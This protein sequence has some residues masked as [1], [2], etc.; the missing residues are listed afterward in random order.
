MP[1]ALLRTLPDLFAP[2]RTDAPIEEGTAYLIRAQ[3][4]RDLWLQW[5]VSRG[6][7]FAPSQ[8]E[9]KPSTM[10]DRLPSLM[11]L[12]VT[13]GHDLRVRLCGPD[14]ARLFAANPTGRTICAG[15]TDTRI[16]RVGDAARAVL[17]SRLPCLTR[18]FAGPDE[19]SV[20][21]LWLPLSSDGARICA[22]LGGLWPDAR[23]D[24]A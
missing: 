24:Q 9:M 12:S 17:Q 14:A 20:E 5:A 6:D 11:M 4:L 7:K 3:T 8:S 2:A 22:V 10:R 23:G 19:G 13:S 16:Q 15:E 18:N 1:N 21:T